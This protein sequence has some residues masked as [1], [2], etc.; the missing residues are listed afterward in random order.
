MNKGFDNK[1]EV[2]QMPAE[3]EKIGGG[4]EV[5]NIAICDDEE[6]TCKDVEEM[7]LAL[8]EKLD[9]DVNTD[10]YYSG[11]GLMKGLKAGNKYE[12]IILDI[13]LT[14]LNG[15]DVGKFI[16]EEMQDFHT[17]I[18]YISS[19]TTYAMQ[20]F[21]MQPLDFLVKPISADIL[22]GVIKRGLE[23]IN[24]S[25]TVFMC[26]S[27]K[28]NVLIECREILYLEG[29]LRTITV[30]CKDEKIV[31]YG[32]ISECLLKLPESFARIHNS[33]IVNMNAI[34]RCGKN[35]VIM[36]NGDKLQISRRF[37]NDF[38]DKLLNRMKFLQGEI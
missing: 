38:S 11:E 17:Q 27:G 21:S 35:F 22:F 32:K 14:E 12:F 16:R 8:K 19:K 28:E 3:T 6:A 30:I 37:S 18:I 23:I 31:F 15:V 34:K 9:T 25:G 29:N 10:V 20:L 7:L 24:Y 26:K 5:F 1:A 2:S 36:N 33:Y 4:S 13:E